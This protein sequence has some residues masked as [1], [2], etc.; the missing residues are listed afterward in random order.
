MAVVNTAAC[1]NRGVAAHGATLNRALPRLCRRLVT[2]WV[3]N[4]Q[5]DSVELLESHLNTLPGAV[6][7]R[8]PQ[9]LL[10]AG[11]PLRAVPQPAGVRG[12]CPARRPGAGAEP[13]GRPGD[14]RS[15]LPLAGCRQ[16]VAARR[17]GH[18]RPFPGGGLDPLPHVL[19]L[20][21]QAQDGPRDRWRWLGCNRR[22]RR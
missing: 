18:R 1:N 12:N 21:F 3:I 11:R 9:H 13:A 2:L 6:D 16:G 4:T 20:F 5:S 7:L 8:H 15:V 19:A 22:G 10:R 17:K 14:A